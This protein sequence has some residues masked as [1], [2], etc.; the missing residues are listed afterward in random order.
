MNSYNIAVLAGDG[1][2]P[3]VMEQA[4]RVLDAVEKKFGFTTVRTACWVG[5]AG[6]DHCGRALPAE[7]LA[8]C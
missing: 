1:I 7:T 6:I 4:L 8:T 2:G 5:G 3:E